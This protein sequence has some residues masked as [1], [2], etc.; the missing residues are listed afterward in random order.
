M[1]VEIGTEAA[2]FPEKEYINGIA[3]AVQGSNFGKFSLQCVESDLV[4]L[5]A[6]IFHSQL[7]RWGRG[8]GVSKC[9]PVQYLLATEGERLRKPSN[10]YESKFCACFT[11]DLSRYPHHCCSMKIYI[12]FVHWRHL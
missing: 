9:C 2:L 12:E 10:L 7:A 3:V 6:C 5:I 8:R 11:E 1:N 4:W